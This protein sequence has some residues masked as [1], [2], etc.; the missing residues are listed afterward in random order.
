LSRR[1]GERLAELGLAAPLLSGA[2]PSAGGLIDALAGGVA[3]CPRSVQSNAV[4]KYVAAQTSTKATARTI[5]MRIA[6]KPIN[7]QNL[8]MGSPNYLSIKAE[9]RLATHA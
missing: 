6:G 2:T 5:F 7:V 8:I 9:L 3:A 4:P 1:S